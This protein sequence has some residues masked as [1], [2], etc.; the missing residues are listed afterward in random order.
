MDVPGPAANKLKLGDIL[1]AV[2]GKP[3]GPAL[4]VD[5]ESIPPDHPY[6]VRVFRDGAEH[7]FTLTQRIVPNPLGAT[8]TF[9]YL[10]VSLAF[11]LTA[12]V[13]AL[14]KPDQRIAQL[15]WAALLTEA[16]TLLKSILVHYEAFLQ[17][18]PRVVFEVLQLLDGPHFA[19]A[20]HFYSRAFAQHIKKWRTPLVVLY[21]W[22]GAVALDRLLLSNRSAL[23]FFAAHL[24]FSN[25]L[26]VILWAFYLVAP[27]S[28]CVAIV[29]NYLVVKDPDEHRRVRWIAV[30]SLAGMLPYAAIRATGLFV[31]VIGTPSEDRLRAYQF[32]L[33]LAVAPAVLIPVVTG[34]AILKHRLFDINVVI[35][36]SIQYLLA[37]S[38]LQ[39]VL[40]LPALAFCYALV[41]NANRTVADVIL[42]N[43]F[44]IILVLLIAIVLNYRERLRNWVDRKFF[45]ESYQQERLLIGL[46]DTIKKLHSV[47]EMSERV[48]VELAATFHPESVMV[49]YHRLEQ[50]AF[51]TGYS[52]SQ[53][54]QGFQISDRSVLAAA[55]GRSEDP[56][57]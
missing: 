19:L 53:R 51:V 44:F 47:V 30:G 48:G 54:T 31:Y 43:G 56:R 41:T 9:S 15:A 6:T 26:D 22:G 50:R 27:L 45:R 16:L 10:L 52:S 25:R 13:L 57:T 17:G 49:F 35:R 7:E 33:A 11:F 55:L 18:V 4:S 36:R 14:L 8:G 40:A 42:H 2:D 21:V 23:A 1:K 3:A 34:Y 39:F 24:S 46:T 32:A 28:A 29:R 38:V 5:L 12:V 37:K 20:Y